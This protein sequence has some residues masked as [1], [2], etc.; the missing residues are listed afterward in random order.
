MNLFCI[1]VDLQRNLFEGSVP[2]ELWALQSLSMIDFD[3][4][5]LTGTIQS[6]IGNLQKLE[7]IDVDQNMLT[8]TLPNAFTNLTKLE[9]VDLSNNRFEGQIPDTLWQTDTEVLYISQNDVV[10]SIPDDFCREEKLIEVDDSNWFADTPKVNCSCCQE[11]KCYMWD[12]DGKSENIQ[13]PLDNLFEFEFFKE[14][15]VQDNVVNETIKQG[16]GPISSQAR[17]CLSPTGCYDFTVQENSD[18]PSLSQFYTLAR[19][20]EGADFCSAIDV[21]GEIIGED[22]T[23]RAGLNH[24][25]QLAAPDLSKLNEQ[26]SATYKALCDVLTRDEMY[27]EYQ[28]CDGSL[29]QRY[30]LLYFYYSLNL[31]FDFLDLATNHTCEW[32]GVSCASSNNFIKRLDLSSQNLKGSIITEIGLLKTLEEIDLSNNTFVGTIDPAT[33]MNLPDLKVVRLGTNEFGGTFPNEMLEFEKL[34]EFN[35]SGNLFVGSL[36][37]DVS[38]SRELSKLNAK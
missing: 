10:G 36:P 38:Y 7:W 21:C 33:Y 14:Y 11:G 30:V 1:A 6:E 24:F 13:C 17:L 37:E 35:I 15:E 20:P 9:Y 32:P 18:D 26:D 29:L 34:T 5:Q 22:H 12:L 16:I 3:K 31:D 27:E 2:T 4:N 28:I 25:T 8:G 19:Y 23:K